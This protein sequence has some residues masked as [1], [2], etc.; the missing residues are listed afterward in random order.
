V[1]C[2]TTKLTIRSNIHPKSSYTAIPTKQMQLLTNQAAQIS[3]SGDPSCSKVHRLSS[4]T[5][6]KS[7]IKIGHSHFIIHASE[8]LHQPRSMVSL[9]VSVPL[10]GRS[11]VPTFSAYIMLGEPRV[12]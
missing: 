6:S 2:N 11:V 7:M 9:F 10:E 1:I 12:K 3:L 4:I 5:I 8:G